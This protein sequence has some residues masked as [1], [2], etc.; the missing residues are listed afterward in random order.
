M[1]IT[2][3]AQVRIMAA[4]AKTPA[5]Q[6]HLARFSTPA[7]ATAPAAADPIELPINQSRTSRERP[8]ADGSERKPWMNQ[9][10]PRS[11]T[12]PTISVQATQLGIAARRA[13]GGLT[14]VASTE[15]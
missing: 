9:A 11:G 7:A 12:A 1:P 8:T 13:S 10:Q 3:P 15:A 14:S 2:A 5:P 4:E 6:P